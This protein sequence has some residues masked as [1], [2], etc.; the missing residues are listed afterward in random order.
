MSC[1]FEIPKLDFVNQDFIILDLPV[2]EHVVRF[3]IYEQ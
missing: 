1:I 2:D 3:V